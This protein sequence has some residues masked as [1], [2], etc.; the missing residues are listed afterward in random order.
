MRI[1]RNLSQNDENRC[2]VG[3]C[4]IG[5]D[6]ILNVTIEFDFSVV[7]FV[8][9]GTFFVAILSASSDSQKKESSEGDFVGRDVEA[10]SFV[11]S[12]SGIQKNDSSEMGSMQ[13][14]TGNETSFLEG[15]ICRDTTC[16]M[17]AV[18]IGVLTTFCTGAT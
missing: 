9:R 17:G 15:A 13:G 11:Y 10:I 7:N 12:A 4:S 16:C 2:I 3:T 6:A 5:D 1:I 8:I 14:I 18:G